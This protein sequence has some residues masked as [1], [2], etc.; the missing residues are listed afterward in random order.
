MGKV[1]EVAQHIG[2]NDTYLRR[3]RVG[4]NGHPWVPEGGRN[5]TACPVSS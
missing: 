5:G 2:N 3:E 4:I 1:V